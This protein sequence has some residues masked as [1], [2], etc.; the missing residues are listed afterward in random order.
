MPGNTRAYATY[1]AHTNNTP[2]L[3][4]NRGTHVSILS[5]C[6]P[7][8]S[9]FRHPAAAGAHL[10]QCQP[11]RGVLHGYC[12]GGI[13]GAAG[14]VHTGGRGAWGEGGFAPPLPSWC[15]LCFTHI[16]THCSILAW[17]WIAPCSCM[18]RVHICQHTYWASGCCSSAALSVCW[19][20][21]QVWAAS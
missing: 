10:H 14:G 7:V 15:C 19:G 20:P 12:W 1:H 17:F 2:R 18:L 6:Y 11:H 21:A 9:Y 8:P 16:H 5:A 13:C 3:L 4:L